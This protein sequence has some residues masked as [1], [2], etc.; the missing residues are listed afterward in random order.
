MRDR[1]RSRVDVDGDK[2]AADTDPMSKI[3]GSLDDTENASAYANRK[4]QRDTTSLAPEDARLR[5]RDR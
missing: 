5:N 2:Q 4:D 1:D 3:P